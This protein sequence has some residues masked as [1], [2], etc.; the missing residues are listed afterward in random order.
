MTQVLH[1]A[2]RERGRGLGFTANSFRTAGPSLWRVDYVFYSL[3]VTAVR[4]VVGRNG[5]SDHRP[6]IVELHL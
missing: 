2:Y 5:G 3:D 6:V 4:A 1:D